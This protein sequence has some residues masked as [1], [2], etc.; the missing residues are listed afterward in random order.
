[1]LRCVSKLP[2]EVK[3]KSISAGA[4]YSSVTFKK[5]AR[6]VLSSSKGVVLFQCMSHLAII[7]YL[8]L[9]ELWHWLRLQCNLLT[10]QRER[11]GKQ[12]RERIKRDEAEKKGGEKEGW[13][14][15]A[16]E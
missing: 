4:A 14:E 10:A 5:R 12:E 1:M 9:S 11:V 16:G 7:L 2:V 3:R 6:A 15:C 13:R 8:W